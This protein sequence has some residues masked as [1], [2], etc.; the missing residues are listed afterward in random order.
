MGVL[1]AGD[2]EGARIGRGADGAVAPVE[3]EGVGGVSPGQ[4][5]AGVDDDAVG[6]A[7]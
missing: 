3:V 5:D 4:L 2:A 6:G 1:A 7:G